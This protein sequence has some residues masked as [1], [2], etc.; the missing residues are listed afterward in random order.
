GPAIR[1]TA[2]APNARSHSACCFVGKSST[3]RWC[4][5]STL[6]AKR[7]P[8]RRHDMHVLHDPIIGEGPPGYPAMMFD[9]DGGL[10]CSLLGES[11]RELLGAEAHLCPSLAGSNPVAPRAAY[12][13][14]KPRARNHACKA[15][16]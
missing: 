8:A 3:V 12:Q 5:R 15:K 11:T 10:S 1:Q 2:A 6:R 7:P 4:A 13:G 16:I 14:R 9:V